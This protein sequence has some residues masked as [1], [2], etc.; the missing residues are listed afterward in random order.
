MSFDP[1]DERLYTEP[2]KKLIES[3]D[4]DSDS[5]LQATSWS[6][7][8]LHPTDKPIEV[9]NNTYFKTGTGMS[10]LTVPK[11]ADGVVRNKHFKDCEFHPAAFP[12]KVENVLIEDEYVPDGIIT[13]DIYKDLL[14]AQNE[15]TWNKLFKENPR[16]PEESENDWISR[17]V[18]IRLEH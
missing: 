2:I 5:N 6:N 1:F 9:I 8:E 10:G 11:D 15:K 7:Q 16:K 17:V 12:F 3:I 18:N 4:S 13:W 14:K